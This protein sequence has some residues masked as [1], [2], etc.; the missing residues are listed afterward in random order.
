MGIRFNKSK[1][2]YRKIKR[3]AKALKKAEV[4]GVNSTLISA[5]KEATKRITSQINLKSG[6]VKS[7]F[8]LKKAKLS[9]SNPTGSVS[10][11]KRGIQLRRFFVKQL[12]KTGKSGKKVPAGIAVKVKK[13]GKI[14]KLEH[15]FLFKLAGAGGY[16]IA[17]RKDG[18]VKV[19]YAPSASQAFSVE[20]DRMSYFIRN[21]LQKRI[22]QKLQLAVNQELLRAIK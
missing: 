1:N 6:E 13:K 9:Q 15:A 19:L 14:K 7:R 20:K 11:K 5:R 18:R 8:E 16:A 21:T 12:A 2:P 3:F 10:T 4:Y 17:G 22:N